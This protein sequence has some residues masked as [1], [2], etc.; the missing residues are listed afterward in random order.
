VLQLSA[1]VLDCAKLYAPQLHL[2]DLTDL[3]A[4]VEV[5][6]MVAVVWRFLLVRLD[7]EAKRRIRSDDQGFEGAA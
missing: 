4:M 1:F 7:F 6:T 3:S 2:T 5:V